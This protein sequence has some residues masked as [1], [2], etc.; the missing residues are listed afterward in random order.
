MVPV[1]AALQLDSLLSIHH[2]IK[3][4]RRQQNNETELYADSPIICAK[5]VKN[6]ETTVTDKIMKYPLTTTV[7]ITAANNC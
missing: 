6:T 4:W 3:K 5:A 7:G 1:R 2:P